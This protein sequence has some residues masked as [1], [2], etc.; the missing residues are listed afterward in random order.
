MALNGGG[1]ESDPWLITTIA[2]L[3]SVLRDAGGAGFYRIANELDTSSYYSLPQLTPAIG[4]TYQAKVIDGD[5]YAFRVAIT[6]TAAPSGCAFA[7]IHFRNI[8]IDWSGAVSGVGVYVL[9]YR[10][11]LTDV[12]VYA[13]PSSMS[14][15][16][17]GQQ[18]VNADAATP[19]L[20]PREV[21]RVV[22]MPL[23]PPG[24]AQ[25]YFVNLALTGISAS[26]CYTYTTLTPT[27]GMTNLSASPTLALLDS[28]SSGAFGSA[29]WW[30]SGGY[31]MP[32]QFAHVALDLQTIV[33]GAGVSRRLWLESDRYAR[34]IG[35][36]DMDGLADLNVRIRKNSSF[37]V[38]ASEDFGADEL[39]AG[40]VITL[41]RWYLPPLD[42]GY[43]YQAG[44]DGRVVS[45]AGVV[46]NDQP[47]TISGVVFTPRLLYKAALSER[48]S[49]QRGG[50]SQ[51]IVLDNSGGGGG[52]PVL[53]GDPAYLDGV[54]EEIHPILG[55]LRVLANA[56]VLVFERRGGEYVAMG[57]AYSNALG[58]FRVNTDVYGGGDIFAFAA[59]FPGVVWEAGA[60][61]SLGDRVRPTVNNGYVYEVITA[62]NSGA[63]EPAWWVDAGDGTEGAIGTAT[64]KARPYYQPVGHGP[65]KMTLVTP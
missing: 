29:D 63:T 13:T 33:A 26:A 46:F 54:V 16:S 15:W 47:V 7:G 4:N 1:T 61:L 24:S 20:I 56:E 50:V 21:T 65:L 42:N 2:E 11:S 5:G 48:T 37:T 27:G 40:K 53:D 51:S 57:S 62:G 58:E 12:A 45:V 19:S 60:N 30:E 31:L 64:A 14:V 25:T 43:V 22:L 6:H 32:W 44:S 39:R 34:Y 38:F 59:D 36:T 18:L 55:T 3:G 35:A 52:G 8:R 41:G 17:S 23:S 28:L 9:F 10:C 49:V